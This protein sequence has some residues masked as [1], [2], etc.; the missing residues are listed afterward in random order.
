MIIGCFSKCIM[1]SKCMNGSPGGLSANVKCE[2]FHREDI[3]AA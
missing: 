3:V 2:M 1:F